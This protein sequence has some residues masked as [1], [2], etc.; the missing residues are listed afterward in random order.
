MKQRLH[1]WSVL[2]AL[3]ATLTFGT[4]VSAQES[5]FGSL[6]GSAEPAVGASGPSSACDGLTGYGDAMLKIGKRWIAG[7]KRDGLADR[8]TRTFTS[9]E[10]D[11]YANR[12]ARL[13]ADLRAIDPPTLAAPWHAAMVE[14]AS[15]KINFGRSA[16]LLGFDYTAQLL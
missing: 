1:L 16:S 13:L 15:L 10:W 5:G 7:M 3:F 4:T 11:D 14:S 6:A 2:F 9:A 8:S 12:A